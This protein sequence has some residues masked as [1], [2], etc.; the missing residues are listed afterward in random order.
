MLKDTIV[1]ASVRIL[2]SQGLNNWSVGR[3]ASRAGCA[4]G[5]VIYHFGSKA[6]L[7]R[8]SAERIGQERLRRRLAALDS[9]R[10]TEALDGLWTSIL[11]DLGSGTFPAWVELCAQRELGPVA[12]P[13]PL[14]ASAQL[15]AAVA[16]AFELGLEDVPDGLAIT[17]LL[18]GASLALL[19]RAPPQDVLAAYHVAWLGMLA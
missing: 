8:R 1:S 15:R 16:H 4:K 19:Q 5:L 3:V 9:A 2:E 12:Q 6:G 10:G 18:D 7:L 11:D 17:A 13:E 14:A